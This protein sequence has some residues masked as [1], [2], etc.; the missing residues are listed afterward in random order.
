MVEWRLNVTGMLNGVKQ[1]FKEATLQSLQVR[2]V[3]TFR[4]VL[5]RASKGGLYELFLW[6]KMV[7]GSP[8]L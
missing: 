1:N 6:V 8:G 4:N 2:L 3:K 7:P 5:P